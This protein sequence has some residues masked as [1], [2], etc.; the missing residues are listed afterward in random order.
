MSTETTVAKRKVSL[1]D[2]EK[3]VEIESAHLMHL[4]GMG[5]E[6]ADKKARE[7]IDELFEVVSK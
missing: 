1:K 5:K 2:F 3:Q 6:K 4:N 7:V